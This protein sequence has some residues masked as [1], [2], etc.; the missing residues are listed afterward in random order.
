MSRLAKKSKKDSNSNNPLPPKDLKNL[1]SIVGQFMEYWGFKKIHGRIWTHLYT[2]TKELDSI[3]LM[4]RLRVSKGL[5]SLAIRDLVK[6]KVI[7]P[8]HTGRHGTTFYT[9]NP[10]LFDVITNVL[11]NR[12]RKMLT[13]AIKASEK[14]ASL[15][16]NKLD[17]HQL[18]L[19]KIQDILSMSASSLVLLEAFLNQ[20]QMT[21]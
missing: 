6:Y 18:S 2:S 16:Q 12:E 13:Q 1:E 14:L 4:K 10:N 15:N 19:E 9:T 7:F 5:M 8:H 21:E 17:S 11:K 3:E 20:N